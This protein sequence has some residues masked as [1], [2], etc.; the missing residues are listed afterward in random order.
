MSAART[1]AFIGG[2]TWDDVPVAVR[3][4]V[5]WLFL[6]ASVA[7]ERA[8]A[9]DAARIAADHAAA[10]YGGSAATCLYDGRRVS[11]PGAA[12]ANGTLMN[13]L[14]L[15]DGHPL[16]K[17]H[18]GAVVIPAALAVAEQVGADLTRLVTAVV[19]GYEIGVRAA[20]QQHARWPLFHSTGTWGT[21]AA[22]ASAAHLLGLDARRTDHALGL[23][24]YH[25]PTDLIM[26]AV[27][28]PSMA[29]DAMGWGAQTGVAAALL[30]ADGFTAHRSEFLEGRSDDGLG[31]RWEVLDVY[32]KPFPCCRW[33][34]PALAAART[35]LDRLGVPG[36]RADDVAR[37]EIRTFEA[38]AGLSRGVPRTSEEAQFNL[39]WPVACLLATGAFDLGCVTTGLGDRAVAELMARVE[40]VVDPAL[41]AG[42]PQVRRSEVTVTLADG[43]TVASG[44]AAAAGDADDPGWTGV[45]RAKLNP[46]DRARLDATGL[47]PEP[48]DGTLAGRGLAD[49]M[50]AL[51]YPLTP[52]DTDR[53]DTDPSDTDQQKE[54]S[55]AHA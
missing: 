2:L 32:V 45:V 53:P 43:R 1:L 13:A 23:A 31:E 33:A 16:A 50:A 51:T 25:S 11:A 30:A 41:T 5:A 52:A 3:E 12:W 27:A 28:E 18:P 15:D 37:I 48:G 17:G 42:F 55:H 10:V 19:V 21:V 22:A 24:E 38:A 20:V 29:K 54:T 9:L 47:N 26:R 49:L 46:A 8:R 44:E 39:P 40:V 7:A 35:L 34:H 14:D 6:D 4:R 36:L